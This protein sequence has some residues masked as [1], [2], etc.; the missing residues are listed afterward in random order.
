MEGVIL[1][2]WFLWLALFSIFNVSVMN[3]EETCLNLFLAVQTCHKGASIYDVR[4]EGG[5]GVGTKADDSTD[6][7]RES[8]SDKM[9]VRGSKSRKFCGRH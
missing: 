1:L 3:P 5:R 7:L 8:Y 6:R 4:T 2:L 9:G